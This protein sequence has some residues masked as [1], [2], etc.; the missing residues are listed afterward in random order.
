MTG[1]T[2]GN[3]RLRVPAASDTLET[4]SHRQ[5]AVVASRKSKVARLDCHGASHSS[6]NG[7]RYD[8]Y[9]GEEY[10]ESPIMASPP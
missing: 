7:H 9:L 6:D 3:T 1:Q 5:Q 2:C 8:G 4:Q 10:L